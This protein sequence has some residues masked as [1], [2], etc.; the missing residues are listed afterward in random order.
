MGGRDGGPGGGAEMG[1]QGAEMGGQGAEMGDPQAVTET[2]QISRTL[3]ATVE[4]WGFLSS[5]GGPGRASSRGVTA[6]DV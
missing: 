1:D 6:P 3:T 2:G 4:G 5:S